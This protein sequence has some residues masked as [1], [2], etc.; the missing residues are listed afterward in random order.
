MRLFW[1][2][3]P[4]TSITGWTVVFFGV[5]LTC[6]SNTFCRPYMSRAMRNHVVGHMRTAKAQ[7]RHSV[8]AY[9]LEPCFSYRDSSDTS[10]YRY[11]LIWAG[12]Q[13]FPQGC[14]CAQ[15]RLRSA[16][17]FAHPHSL[18][19]VFVVCLKTVWILCHPLSAVWRLW[20]DCAD[21]QADLSLRLAHMQCCSRLIC[22]SLY[23]MLRTNRLYQF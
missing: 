13:Q 17:A 1:H 22:L 23:E 12:A 4:K 10:S 8:F 9:C 18:I 20:S 16:C 7:I 14:M 3:H 15:R 11:F 19:K 6:F 5:M 21:A 2:L